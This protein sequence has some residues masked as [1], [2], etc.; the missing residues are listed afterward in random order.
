MRTALLIPVTEDPYITR[1]RRR[2]GFFTHDGWRR[3]AGDGNAP[4]DVGIGENLT[5]GEKEC[6]SKTAD[7]S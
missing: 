3:T 6:G 7:V 4:A 1:A 2:H 5:R